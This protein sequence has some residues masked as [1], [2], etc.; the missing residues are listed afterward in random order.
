[1]DTFQKVLAVALVLLVL[2]QVAVLV[3]SAGAA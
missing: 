2:A 3:A 1:M